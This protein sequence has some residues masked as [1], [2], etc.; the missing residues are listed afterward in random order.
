M[1][2]AGAAYHFCCRVVLGQGE[3]RDAPAATWLRSWCE[4]SAG[5][6]GLTAGWGVARRGLGAGTTAGR[7]CGQA[8]AAAASPRDRGAVPGSAGVGGCLVYDL[9]AAADE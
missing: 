5:C 6:G 9:D 2:T 7:A 1:A 4:C 8:Q 3:G